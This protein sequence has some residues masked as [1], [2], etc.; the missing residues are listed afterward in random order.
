MLSRSMRISTYFSKKAKTSCFRQLGLT[1]IR[2]AEGRVYTIQP[3]GMVWGLRG[4]SVGQ[5]SFLWFIMMKRPTSNN[6]K[7]G[8]Q[9]RNGLCQKSSH[10]LRHSPISPLF[11]STILYRSPSIQY[12]GRRKQTY[13][14]SCSACIKY[15]SLIHPWSCL[16]LKNLSCAKF[17]FPEKAL[18]HCKKFACPQRTGNSLTFFIQSILCSHRSSNFYYPEYRLL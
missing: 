5:P 2:E 7:H 17:K 4:L 12:S 3:C 13:P 8:G 14:A 9:S 1:K 6:T 18:I 16:L 10:S 15:V 11:P